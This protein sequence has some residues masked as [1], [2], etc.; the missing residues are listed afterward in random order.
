MEN[1]TLF[2]VMT[3]IFN[4]YGVPCF[5]AGKTKTGILRIVFGCITFG[6]IGIINVVKGII[7]G[8]KI[9]QMPEDEYQAKKDT[10]FDGIPKD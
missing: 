10:L 3:I 1:K 7:L 8:I 4:S 6:V 2:G 9:L 5:M